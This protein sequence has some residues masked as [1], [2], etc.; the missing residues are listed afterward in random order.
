LVGAFGNSTWRGSITFDTP[1]KMRYTSPNQWADKVF[2]KD[3]ALMP[4]GE[5]G[6]YIEQ[7]QHLPGIP[8]AQEVVEK[9]ISQQEMMVKLLE[10]IEELTLHQIEQNKL[11]QKLV[12][13]NEYIRTELKSLK[14]NR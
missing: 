1:P 11:I 2:K 10:K 14:S 13:E 4:L 9:G 8:S 7:H 6:V 12:S 3:Y 5:L